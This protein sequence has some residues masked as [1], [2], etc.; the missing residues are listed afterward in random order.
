M[1]AARAQDKVVLQRNN[2]AAR[3]VISGTVEDFTGTGLTIRV[4]GDESLKTFPAVDVV[5][6][7]TAQHELHTRGLKLL[8]EGQTE[9]AIHE[10]EAAIKR[11]PRA[12]VRREI[13]AAL[14]RC[15]LRRGDYSS[16]GARFLALL[17]SDPATR[18]FRIVPLVWSPERIT[19][20]TRGD[21]QTWIE[22]KVEAG[23]LIGA[24]LLYDDSELE[25]RSPPQR[26][27]A[28]FWVEHRPARPRPGAGP[29]LAG[30]S[31]FGKP[32]SPADCAVAAAHRRDARR[33]AGRSQFPAGPGLSGPPRLRAWP[34]PRSCGCRW[35]TTTTSGLRPAL[36]SKPALRS[37][38]SAS[39]PK[40][41]RCFAKSRPAS[42]TPPSPTRPAP[43]SN[44]S[45]PVPRI[46]DSILSVPVR[47]QMR[48]LSDQVERVIDLEGE[49]SALGGPDLAERSL[50]L[51]YRA[52]CGEPLERLLP[53]AF[54][55][56]REAARRTIGLS[57]FRVQLL[58][59]A[60]L[61]A[62]AIA[63]MQTGEGKTLTATLPLY[64]RALAGKGAH[65]ATANDYLASRDAD[66]MRLV[67]ARWVS[68]W[69]SSPLQPFGPTGNGLMP[70]TLPTGPPKNSASI[71][72]AT[73][74]SRG[75]APKP[76][77][78][79]SACLRTKP[80]VASP[81]ACRR[82]AFCHRR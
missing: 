58:A 19:R 5:E 32:R 14:V 46:I 34:R 17:K 47:W 53:H 12:W 64:L 69:G 6:V 49:L 23:R 9:Q 77:S 38:A 15:A 57:H 72:C 52:K 42:P 39:R 28:N 43:C 61:N 56:V 30:R 51:R 24:S 3:V 10:L 4:E 40:H 41:A 67:W 59:G 75:T 74:C 48:R 55:L 7:Q 68:R 50:S 70:A 36:A 8:A 82:L 26:P 13:L 25:E 31:A 73:A 44:A 20:E 2:A 33:A 16:A 37:T 62:G 1:G 76:R 80:R 18:Q 71:S 29:G 66:W 78:F 22:G 60:A 79:S 65:L 11:E 45:D 63:E 21:A 54:A 81:H 35:S 27:R